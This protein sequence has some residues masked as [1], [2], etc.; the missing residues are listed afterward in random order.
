[1]KK[2]TNNIYAPL[3]END[4]AKDIRNSVSSLVAGEIGLVSLTESG[5][6][7]QLG[8]TREQQTIIQHFI[9][10]LS[11]DKPFVRLPEQYNLTFKS[12]QK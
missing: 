10:A 7:V 12:N 2:K 4:T 3:C 8:M 1:M 11:K 5:E 9:A 6:I